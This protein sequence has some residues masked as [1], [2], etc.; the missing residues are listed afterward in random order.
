MHALPHTARPV[1]QQSPNT[2]FPLL[3]VGFAQFRLQQLGSVEHVCPF[4]LQP[5]ARAWRGVLKG[6]T[7]TANSAIRTDVASG[8]GL[9]W[10]DRMRTSM[11]PMGARERSHGR[12]AGVKDF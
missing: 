4:D 3:S 6:R 7:A 5:L 2:A 11:L 10:R 8:R 12:V 9:R 1:G